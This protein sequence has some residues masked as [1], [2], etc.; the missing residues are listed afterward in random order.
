MNI[1]EKLKSQGIWWT[2][3][4]TNDINDNGQTD[5]DTQEILIRENLSDEM[6][7]AVFI[8]EIFHTLN[9]TMSHELMDSLAM[10]LYQ[11]IKDNHITCD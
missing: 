1:P 3:R 9:T 8:H 11:V 2:V 5:Y 4:F 6:K 10:Q 7:D